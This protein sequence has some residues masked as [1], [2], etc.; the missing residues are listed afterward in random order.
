MIGINYVDSVVVYNYYS[1]GERTYYYGTRFDGVR[2]ELTQA[3]NIQKNGM[4]NADAFLVKIPNDGSL[5]KPYMPPEQWKKL[6]ED[7]KQEAFTLDKAHNDFVVIVKKEDLGINIT[8][9]TGRINDQDYQSG[10]Y[11]HI[12]EKYGFTYTVNT[13]GV[14]LLIPRFE[15]GGA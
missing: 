1:E 14:Y 4:E 7:Q 12:R 6:V 3:A 2:V 10:F 8:L 15:V 9:P 13:V 11:Q 5:P